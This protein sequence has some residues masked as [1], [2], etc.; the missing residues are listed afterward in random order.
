M[1]RNI[2]QRI[3]QPGPWSLDH[4][5]LHIKL[6]GFFAVELVAMTTV[7]RLF[8]SI[9]IIW[10]EPE[11]SRLVWISDTRTPQLNF[12]FILMF[13]GILAAV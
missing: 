11:I 10:F 13:S 12:P 2:K 4:R 3:Q 1:S 5:V 9:Q 6:S 8:S 7:L